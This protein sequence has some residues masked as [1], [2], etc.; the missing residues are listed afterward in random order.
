MDDTPPRRRTALPPLIALVVAEV[1]AVSVL[2]RLGSVTA[3]ALPEGAW[4]RWLEVTA[5]ED[6]VMAVLRLVALAVAW[7][8]LGSTLLYVT[9]RLTRRASLAVAL[10]RLTLPAV[11]AA[12]DRAVALA[13]TGTVVL[14]PA[15][16]ALAAEVGAPPPVVLRESGP[17]VLVDDLLLHP[18]VPGPQVAPPERGHGPAP[19]ADAAAPLAL[20]PPALTG[21]EGVVPPAAAAD[22]RTAA[23]EVE[24]G[25]VPDGGATAGSDD[26]AG[27]DRLH[28]VAGGEHLWGIAVAR[29]AAT[30]GVAAA[31]LPT[32]DIA[33]AWTALVAENADR[34]ASGDVDLINPGERLVLPRGLD[35]QPADGT[36]AGG[37]AD[38]GPGPDRH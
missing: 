25:T 36:G 16:P 11:R 17:P 8:L 15:A 19:T 29:L 1:A 7:W 21:P 31:D 3:L 9:A 20:L 10:G 18:G 6:V 27:E 5:A 32:A 24:P 34:V 33:R 38:P 12:A 35:E 30:R 23:P 22:G 14:G 13:V 37:A 4:W 28:V 2:H 26:D